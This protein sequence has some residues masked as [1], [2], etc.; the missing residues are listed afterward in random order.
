[1]P[2]NMAYYLHN[3]KSADEIPA[4]FKAS[5]LSRNLTIPITD[6]TLGLDMWHG[7]VLNEHRVRAGNSHLIVTICGK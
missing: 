3:H 2:E 5:L 4:H 7:I 1:V 6:G